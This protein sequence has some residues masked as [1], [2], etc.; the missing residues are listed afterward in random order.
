MA[1]SLTQ[2]ILNLYKQAGLV[3]P[4]QAGINYYS[5]KGQGGLSILRHNLSRDKRSSTYQAP[6]PAVDPNASLISGI[7]NALYPQN[8]TPP[9]SFE[10]SGL[11]NESDAAAQA[12]TDYQPTFQLEQQNLQ[13]QQQGAQG[14]ILSDYN[15]RGLSHSGGLVGAQQN[16]AL[17]Q[18]F[19]TN[20]LQQT[21]KST[22]AG[23][24]ANSYQQAYQRYLNKF[25]IK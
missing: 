17:N 15:N 20:A 18:G 22:L 8:A 9:P 24:K 7:V 5:K 3:T 16:Q 11:Y 14:N 12:N 10:D 2:S 6:A 13:R 19:D 1:S 23:V 4:S 21:Q 25:N